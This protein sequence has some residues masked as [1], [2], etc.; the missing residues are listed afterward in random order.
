MPF[1]N[2]ILGPGWLQWFR[3]R[4]LELSLRLAQGLDAKRARSL[5]PENV[6]TFYGNLKSL[7]EKYD[8]PP[9]QVWNCDESGVQAGQ[10]GGA[11]VLAVKGYRSVHQ[12]IPN[13]REWLTILTCINVS[14]QSIP[15]FYIFQDKRC[16]RNY[17]AKYE[18]GA[19][20]AMFE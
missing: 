14:G 19:T 10:N 6:Q 18:H 11:Y 17:I 3:R 4:H 7:Y 15:N 12:T 9:S 1:T 8:Y 20:M 16:R 13:K 2:G 5:C